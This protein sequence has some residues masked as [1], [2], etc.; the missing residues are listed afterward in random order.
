MA[1]LFGSAMLTMNRVTPD[2]L[3]QYVQS[4]NHYIDVAKK[5]NVE[6]EVQ[7]HGIFDGMPGRLTQL[8][9]RAA[10]APNPFVVG[11]ERYIKMWNIIGECF[12]AEIARRN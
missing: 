2:G 4:L 7:N 11:A 8:K 9:A 1:G 3:R 12:Q 10:G 5:M 6:V